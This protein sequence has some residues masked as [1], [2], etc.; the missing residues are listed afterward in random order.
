MIRMASAT[1]TCSVRRGPNLANYEVGRSINV[2]GDGELLMR[3]SYFRRRWA[4]GFVPGWNCVCPWKYSHSICRD[5]G[6]R[7]KQ[8]SHLFWR[9]IQDSSLYTEQSWKMRV[10]AQYGGFERKDG[11]LGSRFRR[12][13]LRD[14]L[15]VASREGELVEHI[16]QV[17][18]QQ[19]GGEIVCQALDSMPLLTHMI[20]LVYLP[21]RL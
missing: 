6:Q 4:Y 9:D 16:I 20:L 3:T 11:A 18:H 10:L 21:Q 15:S 12:E 1:P 17:R 14:P 2:T 8:Y 5:S 7:P 19:T 13:F